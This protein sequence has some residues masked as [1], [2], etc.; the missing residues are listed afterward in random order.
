MAEH[1]VEGGGGVESGWEDDASPWVRRAALVVAAGV[2]LTWGASMVAPLAARPV[3]Q[4]PEHETQAERDRRK[5]RDCA[6][7]VDC[8]CTGADC[9][10]CGCEALTT[11]GCDAADCASCELLDCSGCEA[12]DCGGLDCGAIDCGGLDCSGCDL[13]CSVAPRVA[14]SV[15]AA[16]SARTVAAGATVGA[17]EPASE[18]ATGSGKACRRSPAVGSALAL[19]APLVLL[20]LWRR[21]PGRRNK[22]KPGEGQDGEGPGEP[23]KAG[24]DGHAGE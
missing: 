8:G 22:P 6:G 2:V 9:I 19:G 13:A 4:V 24:D 14:R 7:C 1:A 12:V 23:E 18:A 16:R 3:R 20:V 21:S 10:D 5:A 11:T 17:G 15:G